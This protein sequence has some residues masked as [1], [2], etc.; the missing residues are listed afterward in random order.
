M[1][2]L[3]LLAVSGRPRLRRAGPVTCGSLAPRE[4]LGRLLE[5]CRNPHGIELFP[6]F[7]S[8]IR[9]AGPVRLSGVLCD[10]EVSMPGG[11]EARDAEAKVLLIE[12]IQR[13]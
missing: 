5:K 7:G 12:R 8:D 2:D 9:F 10:G 13:R 11:P 4:S 6:G 1:P 3:N